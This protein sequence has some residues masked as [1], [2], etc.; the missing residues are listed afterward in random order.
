[1]EWVETTARTIDEAREL[2]L[3][4]LG[5]A[6]DDAEIVVV[7]EPKS[8]LFGRL[9]GEARVRAR[10]RPTQARPK[11]EHR[12][13]RRG[14]GRDGRE[15]R[16]Q[17][18]GRPD[19]RRSTTQA[20]SIEGSPSTGGQPRS[21]DHR[22]GDTDKE[23]AVNAAAVGAQARQFVEDLVAAFG[24]RGETTLTKDGDDLEVQVSGD[25]LGLLVGPRGT[26]LQAVQDLARVAS[27]RRLGDH[28]TRLRVDVGGYRVRRREALIRFAGQVADEVRASGTARALE[29][30]PSS[31]RKVVHEAL[32][33]VD[34]VTTR[35]E[36]DDPYRRVII[37]PVSAG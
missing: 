20:E 22:N 21:T 32:L 23:P 15:S 27:Q 18:D 3:D 17:H 9:R 26:T 6:E 25:D 10:V 1:M 11:V 4:Q 30:M 24:L 12:D 5:V 2:A 16:E 34:G 35:S 14:R 33:G 19:E 13:R 36:G 37:D 31:D 28:S 8:G 7:D 29:P